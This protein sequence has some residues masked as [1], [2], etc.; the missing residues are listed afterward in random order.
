MKKIA[1]LISF[2]LVML[3]HVKGQGQDPNI[4]I[5]LGTPAEG[6][7]I[8]ANWPNYQ[9][10][11]SNGFSLVNQNNTKNFFGLG[12]YGSC[13]NG[14]SSMTYGWIG[15]DYNQP[16]MM[17]RPTGEVGVGCVDTR[18]DKFHVNTG[19]MFFRVMKDGI[20]VADAGW[21]HSLTLS[22]YAGYSE[23]FNN[24]GKPVVLQYSQKGRVGIG[25]NNPA[26]EL[27]VVGT[28]RA[29]EIKVAIK[30]ADFVFEDDYQLMPLHELEVFVKEQKHLPEVASANEMETN[31]TDLGHMNSKLL[32]K[33]EELTLYTIEQQKQID[34]LKV[35]NAKLQTIEEKIARLEA[36]AK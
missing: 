20:G 7:R 26:C 18:G 32:Q 16:F 22:N 12:A 3:S 4:L 24:V 25:T 30:G 23:V 28:I 33:I 6:V 31:G 34:A 14:V 29:Q 35:Q 13:V 10:G 21:Q 2:V 8:K 9:G 5:G 27:D 19:G 11:W 15:S 36:I 17:F 1:L